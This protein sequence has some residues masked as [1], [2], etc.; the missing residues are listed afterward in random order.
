ML[1]NG[2]CVVRSAGTS[3]QLKVEQQSK[4]QDWKNR[5]FTIDELKKYNGKN[6]MPAY[7]AVDGIVYDL[8]GVKPWSG[9]HHM[10]MH[11]AGQDL[12]DAFK[13]KAPKKIHAHALD[14][15]PKVGVLAMVS[16]TSST[17]SQTVST[18]TTASAAV[19]A[20]K[21]I[22]DDVKIS[23]GEIGK[24]AFCPVMKEEFTITEKTPALKYK[25]KIYYFCC[26][27]CPAQFKANPGKFIGV[28]KGA[29]K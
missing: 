29:K 14:K 1:L 8:T 22:F 27:A 5:V 19:T 28:K 16:A 26:P 7:V 4:E 3:A 17:P 10:M 11:N 9:G 13:N 24:K 23:K 15:R 12:T 2:V 21:T 25:N 20:I 6:G 18:V